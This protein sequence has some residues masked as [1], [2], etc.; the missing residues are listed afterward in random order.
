MNN[1]FKYLL[2]LSGVIL[3]IF[4]SLIIPE[5]ELTEYGKW[6]EFYKIKHS[7]FSKVGKDVERKTEWFEYNL[8]DEF[9]ELYKPFRL[10]SEDSLYFIDLDS[11]SLE[12]R[13]DNGKLISSGSEIDRKAQVIRKSDNKA[14][15]L[16]FCGSLCYPET[17]NWLTSNTVE[18][19]GFSLNDKDQFI[20]T[21]WKVDIFNMI[22][23]TY[24][25]DQIFVKMPVSYMEKVR[26][27]KV[28]FKIE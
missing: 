10:Y 21:K 14:A 18:I 26:L 2:L 8:D 7:S 1:F 27:K 25:S 12:L 19:L 15:I 5:K 20:P 13:S 17:S 4:T 6:L 9:E 16:L 23:S 28:E 24:E 22:F 11:Y 3:L